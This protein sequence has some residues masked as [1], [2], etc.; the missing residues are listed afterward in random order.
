MKYTTSNTWNTNFEV[1]LQSKKTLRTL[2]DTAVHAA[3][4]DLEEALIWWWD[5]TF[6][7]KELRTLSQSRT[8]A[9]LDGKHLS[10]EVTNNTAKDVSTILLHP[11]PT[12]MQGKERVISLDPSGAD[13]TMFKNLWWGFHPIFSYHPEENN[14][15]VQTSN[16]VWESWK[17]SDNTWNIGTMA[18]ID[19]ETLEVTAVQPE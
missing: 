15:Y 4:V 13:K 18:V 16:E 19:V 11:H 8:H 9:E 17:Q 1:N 14:V 12:S 3:K 5:T 7:L 6:D 10:E 2:C